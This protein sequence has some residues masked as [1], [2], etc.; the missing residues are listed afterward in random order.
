LY[1]RVNPATADRLVQFAAVPM[2]LGIACWLAALPISAM[3]LV[4][5]GAIA[6]SLSSWR[7]E[8]GLWMLG[9]LFLLLFGG[10]YLLL[11][12]FSI[13]QALVGR[14]AQVVVVIDA[15]AATCSLG[16]AWRIFWAMA[17]WNFHL[18]RGSTD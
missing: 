3:M 13:R 9:G 2:L 10:A 18:P 14:V 8:R 1:L 6:S 11:L 12:E 16:W 17:Y 7:T 5:I 4:G 15:V